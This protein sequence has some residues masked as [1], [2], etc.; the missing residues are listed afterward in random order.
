MVLPRRYLE[1][2]AALMIPS[3]QDGRVLFA[4]P[5]QGVVIAGTTDTPVEQPSLEPRALKVECDFILNELKPYLQVPPQASDVLSVYAGL[6]PLVRSA[7]DQHTAD[8]SRDHVI[9][10]NALGLITI[11][12]GKWTTYR[13]MGED[14]V[15]YIERT[16][17]W[18]HQPSISK[19]VSIHGAGEPS[20]KVIPQL[21]RYGT[22]AP[23]IMQLGMQQTAWM[24]PIHRAFD[25]LQVEVIWQVRNEMAR[26]V[27]DIL[28]RRTR[29]LFLDAKASAAAAPVVAKLLAKELGQSARWQ[30]EQVA[31]YQELAERYTYPHA[32]EIN[33]CR[34]WI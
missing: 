24:Q 29:L 7:K 31:E 20:T 5:W 16:L 21:Q 27:A 15:D 1:S 2:D 10:T 8:L 22:D 34:A 18:P 26:T 3:T 12:G 4:V 23:E 6:R 19:N 32:S 33:G 11:M 17:G 25:Y 9:R 14:L 13:K 28:A 30:R